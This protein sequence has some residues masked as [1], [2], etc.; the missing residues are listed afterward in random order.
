M[1]CG[2]GEEENIKKMQKKYNGL[3]N[4]KNRL[5][6]NYIYISNKGK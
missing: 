3:M 1:D 5:A 4:T 2:E 6:K